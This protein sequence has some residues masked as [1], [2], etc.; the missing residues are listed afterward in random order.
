MSPPSAISTN[1]SI[2]QSDFY[3]ANIPG[4]AKL[5]GAT[6]RS[7]FKYEVVEAI[8]QQQAVGHTGVCGE[9]GGDVK[10]IRYD[11]RHLLK[12]TAEVA[13]RTDSGRLFQRERELYACKSLQQSIEEPLDRCTIGITEN[14]LQ[15]LHVH[16]VAL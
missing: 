16:S 8:P 6:A 7:V 2:N 13:E 10:S 3:S 11:L 9:G 5:R 4:V 1:Q 14:V 15:M 12:V